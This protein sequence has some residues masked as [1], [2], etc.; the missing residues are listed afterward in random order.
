MARELT[1]WRPFRELAP[2][3]EF[4]RVRREMDHLWDSFFE[5]RPAVAATEGREWLPALDLAE[6]DKDLIVKCEVP[7][8]DGK[9]IDISLTDNL[10]TIKGEKAQE[11]EGK[12]ENYHFVERSY[13]SFSRS[14]ELPKAVNSEKITASYKN[15]ILRIVLPKSEETKKKEIKVKVE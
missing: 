13:G 14:I 5:W 9:D 11:K 10:L 6:T 2:F 3:R 15:G 7:G 8:I 4:E 1:K 12:E